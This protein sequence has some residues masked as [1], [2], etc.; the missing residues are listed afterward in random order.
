MVS[1]KK[2]YSDVLNQLLDIEVDW[3][4][5]PLKTLETISEA[6]VKIINK[7]SGEAD[8]DPEIDFP[9]LYKLKKIVGIAR[10]FAK[11]TKI[12]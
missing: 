9:V 6:I 2:E 11:D 7:K 3:T 4:P 12:Q 5:L 1:K 8:N 10:D